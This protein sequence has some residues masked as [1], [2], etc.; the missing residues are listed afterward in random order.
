M[1]EEIISVRSNCMGTVDCRSYHRSYKWIC[2]GK[3]SFINEVKE[4]NHLEEGN[5]RKE[6]NGRWEWNDRWEWRSRTSA[7]PWSP[8]AMLH[9][10][11]GC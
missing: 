5:N 10:G 9:S 1:K 3:Y 11:S 7:V 6:W 2:S 4:G 8:K